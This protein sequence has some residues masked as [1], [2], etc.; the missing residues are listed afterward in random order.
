MPIKNFRSKEDLLKLKKE[1]SKYD[2]DI[3]FESY[4]ILDLKRVK[5]RIRKTSGIPKI[6]NDRAYKKYIDGNKNKLSTEFL[7]LGGDTT[8]VI[9]IKPYANIYQFAK[10]GSD[11]EWL[12]LFNKVVKNFKNDNDY[13]ISTHGHAVSWL[14][15][16]IENRPKY[17]VI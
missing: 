4:E 14:H 13:Y 12:A 6:P 11:R 8:L 7:S 16:R 15:V 1:I 3:Y 17:Y 9:P 2:D 10:E 5:Y